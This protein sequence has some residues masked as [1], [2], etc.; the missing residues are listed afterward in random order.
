M[1][2]VTFTATTKASPEAVSAFLAD[3]RNAMQWLKNLEQVEVVSGEPGTV[4]ARYVLHVDAGFGRTKPSDYEVTEVSATRVRAT[5]H[6]L[7][8]QG[9]ETV[10]LLPVDGGTELRYLGEVE[11]QGISKLATPFTGFLVH[12]NIDEE[13][14]VA[15][16]DEL[17]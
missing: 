6:A 1:T 14:L 15:R 8:A 3:P 2:D 16:L 10:E 5:P 7:N 9:H 4:G 12:Q 13:A 17:A 11:L